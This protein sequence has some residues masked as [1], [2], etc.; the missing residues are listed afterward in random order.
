M[1]LLN[2]KIKAHVFCTFF[3]PH[4]ESSADALQRVISCPTVN[5]DGL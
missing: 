4:I 3:V 5:Y 1:R 2:K